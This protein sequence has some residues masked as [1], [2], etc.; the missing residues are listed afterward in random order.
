MLSSQ[1]YRDNAA[2]CLLAARNAPDPRHR[3]LYLLMAET[4][5]S[6]ARDDAT[7]DD[8]RASW[9]MIYS[10]NV[11]PFPSRPALIHHAPT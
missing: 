5:L 4:F 9:E 2:T 7:M 3:E 6:L 8:L 11:L 10:G 1:R